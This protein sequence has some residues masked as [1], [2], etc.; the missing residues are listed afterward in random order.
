MASKNIR[1]PLSSF[2]FP[3]LCEVIRLFSSRLSAMS[4]RLDD[5]AAEITALTNEIV[6]GEVTAPCATRSGD[7]LATR[8][9]VEIQ[10]VRIL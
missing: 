7:V 4:Q 1:L 3:F 8:G 10:A 9:G 6:A 2:G 5:N